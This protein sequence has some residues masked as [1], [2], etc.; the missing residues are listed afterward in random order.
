MPVHAI[1]IKEEDTITQRIKLLKIARK[2]RI[3]IK[4]LAH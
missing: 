4:I 2:Q 3:Q 1:S